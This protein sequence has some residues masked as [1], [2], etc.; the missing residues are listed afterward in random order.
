MKMGMNLS[1]KKKILPI[2]LYLI[3]FIYLVGIV[4]IL[5][6]NLIVILK[7][8][9]QETVFIGLI[10]FMILGIYNNSNDIFEY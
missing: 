3:L 8:I 4:I 9:H 5:S 1:S 2:I 6:Y 7:A 10:L